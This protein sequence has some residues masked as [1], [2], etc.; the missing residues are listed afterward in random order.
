MRLS[1]D[2][3]D[4]HERVSLLL[5]H[6]HV[7]GR[8]SLC[9]RLTRFATRQRLWNGFGAPLVY[10]TTGTVFPLSEIKGE[11]GLG[12]AN[13]SSRSPF[14]FEQSEGHLSVFRPCRPIIARALVQTT[15]CLSHY[16]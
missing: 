5:V 4:S 2:S 7:P 14:P 13:L 10:V 11:C 3:P 8:I 9:S 12:V 16:Y 15:N 1:H 6:V